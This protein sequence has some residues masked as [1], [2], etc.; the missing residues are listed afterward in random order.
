MKVQ[1]VITEYVSGS[2]YDVQRWAEE[3]KAQG[4]KV[5]NIEVTDYGKD[6]TCEASVVD[7]TQAKKYAAEWCKAVE[8]AGYRAAVKD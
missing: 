2:W 7:G 8:A 3:R 5:E 6:A 4:W 1:R